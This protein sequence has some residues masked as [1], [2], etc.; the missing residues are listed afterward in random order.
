MLE[1]L[2]EHQEFAEALSCNVQAVADNITVV[3]LRQHWALARLS[4]EDLK[5]ATAS[6]QLAVLPAGFPIFERGLKD[7]TAH[8]V[9]KGQATLCHKITHPDDS[10]SELSHYMPAASNQLLGAE[11]LVG[12]IAGCPLDS[13]LEKINLESMSL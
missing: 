10:A 3:S 7:T 12:T 5:R 9:L 1:L 2:E 6:L 13:T 11:P 4:D 8:I